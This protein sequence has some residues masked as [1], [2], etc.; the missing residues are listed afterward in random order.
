MPAHTEVREAVPADTH[1]IRKMLEAD[2]P[3]DYVPDVIEKW[4]ENREV[5]VAVRS[6]SVAGMAHY[7]R[8]PD[9]T[10][11]LSGLRVAGSL[12]RTGVGRALS[13]KMTS[14]PGSEVFRLMIS[15]TN[16]PSV[17]LSVQEGFK[18]RCTVSV[19]RQESEAAE[20]GLKEAAVQTAEMDYL[21]NF[22]GLLPT[23]WFAF[24]PDGTIS[25]TLKKFGLRYV[26]DRHGN[27]FLMNT[28]EKSLTPLHA[29]KDAFNSIPQGYVLLAARDESLENFGLRKTLWTESVGIFEYHRER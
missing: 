28:H 17:Q 2:D 13:R 5:F 16:K 4:I 15:S 19:W 27:T 9:G 21:K 18:C 23:A 11:W 14:I 12:R 6:G 7:E 24:V 29:D 3:E 1:S 10:I 22:D 25:S 26:R 8:M 20:P